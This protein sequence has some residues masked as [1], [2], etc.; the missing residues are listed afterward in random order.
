MLKLCSPYKYVSC[1]LCNQLILTGGV[2]F[3]II[4]ELSVEAP[5]RENSSTRMQS[6]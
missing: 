1:V 5:S 3:H 2:Y 4:F 6:E